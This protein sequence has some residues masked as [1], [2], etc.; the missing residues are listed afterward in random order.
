MPQ[1]GKVKIAAQQLD[2]FVE[3]VVS[4]SGAGISEENLKKVFDPLFT[5]KAKGTGLGLAICQQ[6]MNRHGGTIEVKSKLGAGTAFTV[7][8]PLNSHG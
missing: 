3:L 4:D 1:G 5:T 6:I 2:G 7:R 8:L